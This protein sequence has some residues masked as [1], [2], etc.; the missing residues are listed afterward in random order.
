[1]GSY[2]SDLKEH[3]ISSLRE[4][5]LLKDGETPEESTDILFLPEAPPLDVQ[6]TINYRAALTIGHP[7]LG[8][9]FIHDARLFEDSL[10]RSSE[11][12]LDHSPREVIGLIKLKTENL[13]RNHSDLVEDPLTG[14]LILP[15]S[16][17]LKGFAV[18]DLGEPFYKDDLSLDE[19]LNLVEPLKRIKEFV[20][21]SKSRWN[22]LSEEERRQKLG[23]TSTVLTGAGTFRKRIEATKGLPPEGSIAD[24]IRKLQRHISA[25]DHRL[26][27]AFLRDWQGVQRIRGL[28][29][30]GKT[31]MLALKAFHMHY[32]NPEWNI[33]ITYY[34]RSLYAQFEK[35]LNDLANYFQREINPEKIRVMHAWGG[36]GR[37]GLYY[38]LAQRIG[39]E[40]ETFSM[41]RFLSGGAD[42]QQAFAGAVERLVKKLERKLEKGEYEPE[43]DAILID[44]AQDMPKEFFRMVWLATKR[45]KRIAYAYDEM[46]DLV[47]KGLPGP[48]ELFGEEVVFQEEGEN[49]IWLEKVYRTNRFVLLT[50]HALGFGIYRE[51]GQI[52]AFDPPNIWVK[53]GYKVKE[54]KLDFGERVVLERK[55]EAHDSFSEELF[56]KE[57]VGEFIRFHVFKE[58]EEEAQGV[59]TQ[60]KKDLDESVSQSNI[61]IVAYKPADARQY[62]NLLA[63]HAMNGSIRFHL[64]GDTT[65]PEEVFKEDSIPVM[66]IYRAKGLEAPI[67]YVVGCEE[68][69]S[70]DGLA[71]SGL[72]TDLVRRRNFIFTAITRAH[73]W[74]RIFGSGEKAEALRKEFNRLKEQDFTFDF[75]YPSKSEVEKMH[76]IRVKAMKEEED[77]AEISQLLE[78]SPEARRIYKGLEKE[79]GPR[80]AQEIFK[81]LWLKG[82]PVEGE[83]ET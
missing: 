8:I 4:I 55:K 6:G 19:P 79:Y 68:A 39:V 59:L 32:R 15:V 82:G 57:K 64:V 80:K 27:T 65:P 50:A 62:Y 47:G 60:L 31:A 33:V 83:S 10:E 13:L 54:G 30:S 12:P 23:L 38:T 18:G 7:Q 2:T 69:E 66:H 36:R 22:A 11:N 28:A 48:R 74:V 21:S 3:A 51:G 81:R 53:I 72:T 29:G 76:A 26:L 52:Q 56:P 58:R 16:Y 61:L 41:A 1:M 63:A 40:P 73:G 9:V 75:V 5:G 44:E 20:S 71:I 24:T 37:A 67:V 25:S 42:P 77:L 49:D 45:P 34:S 43:Y 78:K 70:S 17:I 14:K 35:I 46:Q